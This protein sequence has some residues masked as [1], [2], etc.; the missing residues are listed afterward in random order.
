MPLSLYLEDP[1]RSKYYTPYILTQ[2]MLGTAAWDGAHSEHRF[3]APSS[4]RKDVVNQCLEFGDGVHWPT[5]KQQNLP[6]WSSHRW[7]RRIRHKI[8]ILS[9]ITM[10]TLW[11]NLSPPSPPPPPPPPPQTHIHLYP[12]PPISHCPQVTNKRNNKERY[13]CDGSRFGLAVKGQ[14]VKQK[15]TAVCFR[16]GSFLSSKVVVCEHCLVT[17]PPHS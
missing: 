10:Y 5:V 13:A 1:S 15:G 17:L 8:N 3:P 6:A 12:S 2:P 7:R 4:R 9:Y 14:A 16:F 11:W